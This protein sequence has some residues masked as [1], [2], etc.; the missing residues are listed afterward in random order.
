MINLREHKG[1]E[2]RGNNRPQLQEP[3]LESHPTFS[4]NQKNV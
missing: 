2:K 3:Q 1:L 4:V